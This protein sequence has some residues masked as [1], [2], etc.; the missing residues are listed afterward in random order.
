MAFNEV[1]IIGRA[2]SD[3][4]QKGAGPAKFRLAHGGG[5]S[6]AGKEYPVQF[7]SV[8]VWDKTEAA[9]VKKGAKL[10][11]SGRLHDST[12]VDKADVRHYQTD[13]VAESIEFEDAEKQKPAVLPRESSQPIG[14][15]DIPF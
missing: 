7:F 1:S 3:P 8:T 14:D 2:C 9:K 6:K 13:I 12:W 11:I 10:E 5:K 15:Q 4:E